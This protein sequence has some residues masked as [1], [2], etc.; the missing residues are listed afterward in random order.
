MSG[1]GWAE[2]LI[3]VGVIVLFI[4]IP[5]K[6][7][8]L[9]R[10]MGGSIRGFKKGLKEGEEESADTVDESGKAAGVEEPKSADAKGVPSGKQK[11]KATSP[12]AAEREKRK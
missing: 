9:A 7:P 11:S 1:L 5:R 12:G 2:I 8:Q 10:S 3:I 6:L 4:L